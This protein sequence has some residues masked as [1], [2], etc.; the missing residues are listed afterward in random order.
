MQKTTVLSIQRISAEGRSKID[1]V[2]PATPS[3]DPGGYLTGKPARPPL[4]RKTAVHG[5][6]DNRRPQPSATTG[7]CSR[8]RLVHF[9]SGLSR[10]LSVRGR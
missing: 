6:A 2:N 4:R 5:F 8:G 9:C 1:A 7:S 3:A 10:S